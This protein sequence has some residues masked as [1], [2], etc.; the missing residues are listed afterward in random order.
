[1]NKN[2][3]HI[4]PELLLVTDAPIKRK[5]LTI[6]ELDKQIKLLKKKYKISQ[7]NNS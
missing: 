6:K 3:Q 4:I 1:M 7:T 2:L 5:R